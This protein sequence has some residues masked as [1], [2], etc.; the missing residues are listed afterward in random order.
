MT[1]TDSERRALDRIYD[2]VKAQYK[3]PVC[4]TCGSDD[5]ARSPWMQTSDDVDNY[6][7][8]PWHQEATK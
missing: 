5:P 8:D 4:P 3:P 7:T 1:L 2:A 6:C